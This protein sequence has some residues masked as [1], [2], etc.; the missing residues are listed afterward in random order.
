MAST[1]K[2]SGRWVSEG[3]ET[4]VVAPEYWQNEGWCGIGLLEAR[5]PILAGCPAPRTALRTAFASLIG[6]RER[7]AK[8]KE[9]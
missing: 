7:S 3:D 2:V 9:L 8:C 6:M 5:R 4:P 1:D